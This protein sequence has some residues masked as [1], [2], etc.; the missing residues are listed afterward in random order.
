MFKTLSLN[1]TGPAVFSMTAIS[2]KQ[3]QLTSMIPKIQHVFLV[4]VNREPFL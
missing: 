2:S 4:F 1:S 3:P